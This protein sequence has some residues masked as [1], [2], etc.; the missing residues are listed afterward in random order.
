MP[1]TDSPSD[2]QESNLQY[3]TQ[4]AKQMED[5]EE[6]FIFGPIYNSELRDLA[7]KL[8]RG[9][10]GWINEGLPGKPY[11]WLDHEH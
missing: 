6:E 2:T 5:L 10:L 4:K 3:F 7:S 9:L 1:S 11:V 8:R